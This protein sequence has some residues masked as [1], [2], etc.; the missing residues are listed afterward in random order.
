M[1]C[2]LSR[3]GPPSPTPV[4]DPVRVVLPCQR[5][6]TAST[7]TQAVGAVQGKGPVEVEIHY[8]TRGYGA[9][10]FADVGDRVVLVRVQHVRAAGWQTLR[11]L[12][13]ALGMYEHNLTRTIRRL[14]PDEPVET[15]VA[16]HAFISCRFLTSTYIP[17]R[18]TA[19]HSH[20]FFGCTALTAI[21]IPDSVTVICTYA[22]YFCCSL[23][24]IAIPESV[25]T[26]E[27]YA[28]DACHVLS[29]LSIPDSVTSI[30]DYA[31]RGCRNLGSVELPHAAVLGYHA[32]HDCGDLIITRR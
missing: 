23:T 2:D 24:S 30:G 6:L 26:I 18:V 32:F 28:F 8:C 29:S 15:E 19:I 13:V 27:N 7:V 16:L 14:V 31:F 5:V 3:R 10:C 1:S 25:T 17:A 9:K 20:A 22:F 21:S 12:I 11:L 4:M